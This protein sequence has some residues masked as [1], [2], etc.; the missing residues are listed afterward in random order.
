MVDRPC[1]SFFFLKMG[2]KKR[3]EAVV[4]L[5]ILGP[6]LGRKICFWAQFFGLFLDILI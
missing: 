5:S 2:G 1:C 3:D 6:N 4:V